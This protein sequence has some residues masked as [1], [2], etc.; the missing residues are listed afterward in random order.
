MGNKR[1][2][3][4]VEIVTCLHCGYMAPEIDFLVAWEFGV[5][6]CPCCYQQWVNEWLTP[7]FDEF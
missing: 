1:V 4:P 7:W 5:R 3:E 6:K 2:K